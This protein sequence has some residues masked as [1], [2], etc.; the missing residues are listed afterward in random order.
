MYSE[1]LRVALKKYTLWVLSD[2]RIFQHMSTLC[3]ALYLDYQAT[4][5][6][7][8]EVLDGMMPYLTQNFGNPHSRTH[9]YG[10]L[11]EEAVEKSREH[12]ARVI[13]ADPREVIFTSGATESNNLAIKGLAL[14]LRAQN[15][16]RNTFITLATEHKCVLESFRWLQKQGFKVIFLPV[17]SD[18]IVDL[19]VLESHLGPETALVSIMGVNNE[20]GVIQPLAEIGALCE[21]YGAFFHSDAAQALGRIPISVQKLRIHLLSI[22]SHKIYGPKGVGALCV[23]RHPVRVRLAPLF[24]GGGQERG[25][26]SGT[27]PTFLCVGLGIAAQKAERMRASEYVRLVALRDQFLGRI[28]QSLPKVYLNGT[29]ENRVPD[30]LNLSFAGVEGEGLLMG[31]KHLALSSGSACTSESLEPSYVLKALGVSEDLAHTSLRISFGRYTTLEQ[32][33]DAADQIIAAVEKLRALSPLW[34]MITEGIDL[35]T[36]Q[37]VA[38]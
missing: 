12:I 36:V 27:L 29:L 30:N 34:D 38:H 18:G 28:Q 23:R 22:S 15:S 8:P 19:E 37:W 9:C 1:G 24:H 26:R 35:N 11:S 6:C 4:T 31:I 13:E 5:P 21:Q 16:C 7:D 20:I 10:W 3:Q 17:K 25:M 32:S 14:Y 33:L 2:L